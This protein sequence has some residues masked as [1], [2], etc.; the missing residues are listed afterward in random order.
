MD[1]YSHLLYINAVHRENH[2]DA[3]V[4][5]ALR[6]NAS[7]RTNRIAAVGVDLRLK[8][9]A[10]VMAAGEAINPM[11]VAG[12]GSGAGSDA[13]EPGVAVGGVNPK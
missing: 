8:L 4:N 6:S 3:Y 12:S 11:P 9:G 7:P 2:H 13:G 10:L 5:Y 1:T